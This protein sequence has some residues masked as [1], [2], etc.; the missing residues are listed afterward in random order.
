MKA[1]ITG[2]RVSLAFAWAGLVGSA[3]AAEPPKPQAPFRF[4]ADRPVDSLHI[5]LNLNVDLKQKSVAG[6]ASVDL[7]AL[8]DVSTVTFD[9]ANLDVS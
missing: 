3:L 8:R 6:T 1:T 5:R 7:D 9:A 4:P 2:R